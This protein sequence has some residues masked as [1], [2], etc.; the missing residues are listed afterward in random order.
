[1][2]TSKVTVYWW[3]MFSSSLASVLG[4]VSNALSFS[5]VCHFSVYKIGIVT[6]IKVGIK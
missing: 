5:E 1:M 4:N 3:E 2:L 6:S